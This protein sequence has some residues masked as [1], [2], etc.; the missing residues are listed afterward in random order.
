[1]VTDRGPNDA[2]AEAGGPE[3]DDRSLRQ[4]ASGF[5]APSRQPA[6]VL[7]PQDVADVLR[8]HEAVQV[9]ERL[10]ALG[11]NQRRWLTEALAEIAS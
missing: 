10:A 2:P 4:P 1:M 9:R 11:E 3:K 8:E 5:G 7:V 6:I